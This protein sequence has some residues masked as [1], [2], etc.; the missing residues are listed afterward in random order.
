[1][2]E[3][4]FTHIIVARHGEAEYGPAELASVLSDHGGWLTENWNWRWVFYVNVPLGA[5]ALAIMMA[6][7]PSRPINRRRFDL[8]GFILVGLALNEQSAAAGEGK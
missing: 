1:M 5:L 3:R 2:T 6:E 8:T 4:P 7:L